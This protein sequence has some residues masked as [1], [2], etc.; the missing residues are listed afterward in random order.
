MRKIFFLIAAI[1]AACQSPAQK[2]FKRNTVYFEML[3]N[4]LVLSL[5]YERQITSKPGLGLHAGVGLAGDKPSFP[6][7]AKYLFDLSKQRSFLEVGAGVTIAEQDMWKENYNQP[8]ENPYQAGFIPSIG[9]RH[10]SP[11]G[12]MWRVN[13][14]PVFNSNRTELLYFGLSIGWRI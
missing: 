8:H 13:Y 6:L 4:G 12:F 1:F 2:S 9:Y 11:K 14:T 5:N 10:H 7:G 3:G